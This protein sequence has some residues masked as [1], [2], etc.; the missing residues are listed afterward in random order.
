VPGSDTTTPTLARKLET[1]LRG[2]LNFPLFQRLELHER[3]LL[4]SASRATP[5]VPTAACQTTNRGLLNINFFERND[6]LI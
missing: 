6:L 2:L 4:K 5:Y 1:P 3:A